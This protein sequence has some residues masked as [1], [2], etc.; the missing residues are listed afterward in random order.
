MTTDDMKLVQQFA[1]QQ[2]E[3]ALAKGCNFPR[4]QALILV[5]ETSRFTSRNSPI[6]LLLA[7][8]GPNRNPRRAGILR[9]TNI[10]DIV[11]KVTP[12]ARIRVVFAA[13]AALALACVPPVTAQPVIQIVYPPVI[14]EQA[15]DH[16]AFQVSATGS[17][18]LLYQWYQS[19][20]LLAGQTSSSLVLTNIQT[21]D[22]GLYEVSVV[23][24]SGI[25]VTNSV[26]LN[27]STT[28]FP[29][30]PTNLVV[31]R[32]GDGAQILSGA[33]GNTIYLDQYTTNGTYVSSI[34]VPD[35]SMGDSYGTGSS[36]SV[37]GSPALL[38]PGTGYDYINAGML[39]LSPN[40][41]FLSFGAYCENYPF[42]GT[43]V[44]AG[45]E[46]QALLAGSGRGHRFRRV[47]ARLYQRQPLYRGQRQGQQRGQS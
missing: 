4:P 35:E 31:L 12:L 22:S 26:A 25:Y 33:T 34:Q 17:G 15:G 20:S 30:Y 5:Q 9:K 45:D 32:V 36:S 8:K 11:A 27:V 24:S 23:D 7:T 46:W 13:L 6:Q 14:N 42:S 29:L 1:A 37:Y 2:S 16:V 39:T 44:T 38:L 40:Q 43:D 19:N 10:S 41:Q 28:P 47:H 3:N 21:A 18:T